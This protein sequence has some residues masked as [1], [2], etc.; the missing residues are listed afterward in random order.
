M[1]CRRKFSRVGDTTQLDFQGKFVVAT[2]R[3]LA[4]E[5]AS[6]RFREDLYYRLCAD[7]IHTPTL[8]EQIADRSSDLEDLAEFIAC[9]VLPGIPEESKLL[10]K[11]SVEW[12]RTHLGPEYEWPGNIRELEQCVRNVMIRKSYISVT[13]NRA[14]PLSLPQDRLA[15]AVTEGRFSLEELT[16]HYVCMIYAAEGCRYDLA[17]KRLGID[18]RTLKQR[19]KLNANLVE[20]YSVR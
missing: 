9:R 5:M 13:T 19:L 10:A 6:H 12:I 16:Q 11:E 7:M 3:D 17:A 20:M 8:R 15:Q 1:S 4:Q 18:W 14:K 2:N